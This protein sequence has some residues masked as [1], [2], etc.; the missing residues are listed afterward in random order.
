MCACEPGYS[1]DGF[2]CTG[3]HLTSHPASII[4]IV[5]KNNDEK[6][7]TFLVK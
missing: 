4:Y 2:N 3:M 5:V 7:A 6:G 1:G